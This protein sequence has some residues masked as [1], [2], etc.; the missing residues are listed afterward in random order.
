[1]QSL[2]ATAA[3]LTGAQVAS[4]QNLLTN[5]GFSTGTLTPWSMVSGSAAVTAYGA[6]GMPAPA[7][8]TVIGGG[9]QLLG[10][11][12]NGA[13]EQVV[14]PTAV[15]ANASLVI[16]GY[17]GGGG[18]DNARMVVRF[19]TANGTQLA[20]LAQPFVTPV[21]RN[22]EAVLLHRRYVLPW[23]PA[24]TSVAVRI[25]FQAIGCCNGNFGAADEISATI[26]TGSTVPAPLPLN[27]ELLTNPGFEAGWDGR[28]PLSLTIGGW[29]GA[30]GSQSYLRPY[31][32]SAAQVPNGIVSCIVGGARPNPSCGAGAAGNLLGHLGSTALRQRLDVRGNT[33]QFASGQVSLRV[34]ALLGGDL[35][36]GDTAQV[37]FACFRGST[38]LASDTIGP[39]SAADRNFET[40]VGQREREIVIPAGTE[41]IDV[42]LVFVDLNCCN[43]ARALAD[44]LSAMLVPTTPPTPVPLDVNLVRN[45]SFETGSLAGSPLELTNARGW[46]GQGPSRCWAVPF[47]SA[48]TPP[49]TFAAARGLGAQVLRDGGAAVLRQSVDL[50]GSRTLIDNNRMAMQAS[51]W[52]GGDGGEADTAHV[53]ISFLSLANTVLF[54][55][56]LPPVTAAQ[57]NNQTTML[58]RESP[59]IMVPPTTVRAVV[60]LV[61]TDYN[62]CNGSRGLADDVRLVAFDITQQSGA[63]PFPGTGGDIVLM[64]GIDEAPRTGFGEYIKTA[65]PGDVL[66]TVTG[67]PNG[68]LNGSPMILA[69][70]LFSSN[71][72][73]P[74]P[75]FPGLALDPFSSIGI[76]NGLGGGPAGPLLIPFS[77]GGNVWN[78]LIPSGFPRTSMRI[79]ALCLPTSSSPS[80]YGFW[81]SEGHEIRL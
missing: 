42:R 26:V 29:E 30:G 72:P 45:A 16:E 76:F 18:D 57:R 25:E 47:G 60:E 67:S 71:G 39:V 24:A 4:A 22:F 55:T 32:N 41:Y 44:N 14:T 31:S 34:A 40:V 77:Q 58:L 5:G 38:Q 50:S 1:M 37:D 19:L 70:Q 17:L 20:F 68:T 7:V 51:A 36:E 8:G 52:L 11:V 49:A 69:V 75:P 73:A 46:S 56:M 35:N 43:G 28:S 79:Q 65:G 74:V 13:I 64:T 59:V 10:D 9:F 62:C 54:Q 78:Q 15:P 66:R 53:L 3:V 6:N 80:P 23:P 21:E 33:P 27:T 61:F 63:S 12:G 48:Q 2:A 81:G